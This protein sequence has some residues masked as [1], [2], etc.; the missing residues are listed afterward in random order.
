[1]IVLFLKVTLLLAVALLAQPLLSRSSAALRHRVCMFA[2]AG[3][4]L[5]PLTMLAPPEA[6]AFRIDA[7]E[8]FSSPLAATDAVLNW[9]SSTVFVMVWALG[10]TVLL[11]RIATG[12]WALWRLLRK[13]TPLHTTVGVPVFVA[14]VSV[15]VVSGPWRPVILLPR[16][17]VS[18]T[19]SW[20]SAA[21]EHELQHVER[22]DLWA[23]LIGHLACAV[24]WFHPLTWAVARR[25]IHEQESACDDAVLA[26][27]FEPTVYA[28]ALLGAARRLTSPGLIGCQMLTHKTLKHR[29]SRLFDSGL[30]RLPSRA[31]VRAATGISVAIIV[32][33]GM[34]AGNHQVLAA[35]AKVYD[36]GNGVTA[37]KVLS[38]VEADYTQGAEDKRV[39]GTVFMVLVIGTDGLAHDIS[40]ERGIG[41]G[42]DE[43]AVAALQQWRF[44]PGTKDGKPV[45]VRAHIEINFRRW[46][47]S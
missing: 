12:H 39:Q 34:L 21:L 23:L 9:S 36:I 25:S 1:M 28:E 26:S 41:S 8:V 47:H 5:L 7:S 13:A 16:S 35:D 20:R 3:G 43:K 32:M 38:K 24:Y 4:L 14:D 46:F 30:A 33:I 22:R 15:P 17:A 6:T 2:L 19:D 11:I 45:Q 40:V 44:Q 29:I 42:L 37:P 18:W 27:G 10:S 31:G